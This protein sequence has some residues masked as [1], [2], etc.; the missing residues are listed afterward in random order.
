MESGRRG[1]PGSHEEGTRMASLVTYARST[2][3]MDTVVTASVETEQPE[4]EV[5]AALGRA[6]GW[7]ATVERV[8]S[9][10]DPESELVRLCR[11]PGP[12]VPVSGL[13]F[14]AVDFALRIS[15]LTRGVFDPTVGGAQQS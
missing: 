3:A 5:E 15:R 8:C 11:R 7:F 9:R 13:L 12:P 1:G 14:E 10:F 6:L 4:P 2:I